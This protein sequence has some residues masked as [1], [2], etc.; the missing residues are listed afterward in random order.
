MNQMNDI[1]QYDSIT[2]DNFC[3]SCKDE[4]HN[5]NIDVCIRGISKPASLQIRQPLIVTD[6]ISYI[7]SNGPY[8]HKL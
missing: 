4:S 1:T 8:P 6:N 5:F 2:Y 3:E 7:Y